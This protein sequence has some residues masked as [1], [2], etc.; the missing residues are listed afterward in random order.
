MLGPKDLPYAV[1]GERC[2]VTAN[3]PKA[4]TTGGIHI[5]DNAM[6]R[7]FNGTLIDAGLQARDKLRDHGY[8]IGDRVIFGRFAGI[9]EEWDHIVEG[10]ADLP[11]EAYKWEF[12]S[13]VPGDSMK[14]RCAK[15]GA[16]RAVEPAVVLNCDDLIASIELAERRRAGLMEYVEARTTDGQMQHIVKERIVENGHA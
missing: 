7:P 13:H 11:D 1:T 4:M 9:I 2:F 16:V 6:V 14:Y 5:P 12:E 10:P 3:P 15:T 8:R